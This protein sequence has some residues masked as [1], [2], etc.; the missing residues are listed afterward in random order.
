M[1]ENDADIAPSLLPTRDADF[2]DV[3]RDYLVRQ[4]E[5]EAQASSTVTATTTLTLRLADAGD[6]DDIGRLVQGLADYENES[7]AVNIT[8]DQYRCDGFSSKPDEK[9]QPKE[10]EQ[11]PDTPLSLF[12]CILL[13]NEQEQKVVGMAFC[14]MVYTLTDPT[15]TCEEGTSCDGVGG[16]SFLYLE[17]LF[18]EEAYR[19]R[20][21]GSLVMRALA[22]LGLSLQCTHLRWQALEWDEPALEFYN[23]LGAHVMKGRLTSRYTGETIQKFYY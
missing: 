18:I 9:Q 1:G 7:D 21:G 14:Y 4:R 2:R 23:G 12:F 8:V 15:T 22:G 5:R 11:L 17:D 13:H 20:G 10:G 16:G 19:G 6:L 3:V